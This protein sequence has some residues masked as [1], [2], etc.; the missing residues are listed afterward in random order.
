[1]SAFTVPAGANSA[2]LQVLDANGVDITA[3]C[4]VAAVS[5]DSTVIA[6][7]NPDPTTPN[8]IP[9]TAVGAEG[10]SATVTYTATNSAGSTQQVDTLTITVTAPATINVTYGTTI[11][12]AAVHHK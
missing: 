11:P 9:F 7:G 8:V 1:M 12:A 4:S 10:S 5:S 3:G 2:T 6:I